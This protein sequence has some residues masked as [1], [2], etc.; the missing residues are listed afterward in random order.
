[1]TRKANIE[2]SLM[3][4]TGLADHAFVNMLERLKDKGYFVLSDYPA[5]TKID[6]CPILKELEARGHTNLQKTGE[7]LD[8]DIVFDP[9][10]ILEADVLKVVA[11]KKQAERVALYDSKV[12]EK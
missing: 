9:S 3:E 7:T 4:R 8:E 5:A 11:Q 6:P 2:L 1:M 10:Q 12:M